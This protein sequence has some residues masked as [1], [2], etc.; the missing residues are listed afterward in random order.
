LIRE[1]PPPPRYA[2]LMPKFPRIEPLRLER[3]RVV[4]D[5]SIEE[6]RCRWWNASV[7]K[8]RETTRPGQRTSHAERR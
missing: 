5:G 1:I 2:L 7:E 6:V 3:V 4:E 8:G